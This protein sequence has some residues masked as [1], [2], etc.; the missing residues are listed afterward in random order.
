MRHR[1]T[2]LLLIAGLFALSSSQVASRQDEGKW[3]TA[4]LQSALTELG[5]ETKEL[6]SSKWEFTVKTTGFNIP[7][8]AEIS[9]SGNYLWLTVFLGKEPTEAKSLVLLKKNGSI[10]PSFFYVTEKGSL[11]MAIACENRA[12]TNVAL[13]RSIEKL[14]DDVDKTSEA[15]NKATS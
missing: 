12:L 14:R 10:Q 1:A 7:I 13:R 15:W 2:I 3:D 9:P 11:M 5:Y 6:S 4:R 8:G